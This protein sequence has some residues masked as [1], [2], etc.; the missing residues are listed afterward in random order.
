MTGKASRRLVLKVLAAPA[1][2]RAVL[3]ARRLAA[4]VGREAEFQL[5]LQT[6]MAMLGRWIDP[7][8]LQGEVNF[9][10]DRIAHLA[11][12]PPG[13]ETRARR[14]SRRATNGGKLRVAVYGSFSGAISFGRAFFA[15][16]PD[17]IELTVFD[18]SWR[19]VWADSLSGL[20]HRYVRIEGF[21]E[22][23]A[24]AAKI[25]NE[26]EVDVFCNIKSKTDSRLLAALET[27]CI[28][29]WNA[30]SAPHYGRLFDFELYPQCQRNYAL[31]DRR[32]VHVKTGVQMP[33]TVAYPSFWPTDPRE[34]TARD[35]VP[36]GRRGP[37]IFFHGALYK[38]ADRDYLDLLFRVMADMPATRFRFMGKHGP[39]DELALIFDRARVWGVAER[40]EHLG[41]YDNIRDASDSIVDQRWQSCRRELGRARLWL[42]TFPGIGA[43]AR[44][45]AY[46]SG[47]PVVQ[48]GFPPE[49]WRGDVPIYC[50]WD[51]PHLRVELGVAT[52][53]AAYESLMRR[54]LSDDAFAQAVAEAQ[55]ARLP[56]ILD[57]R[58]VWRDLRAAY[59]DWLARAREAA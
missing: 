3:G 39:T 54:I 55:F 22:G 16:V 7:S 28:V 2:L 6:A 45:E 35:V 41:G 53:P 33:D 18:V 51:L 26:L 42:G 43:S 37:D 40:V 44:V 9:H 52:T 24:E 25:A 56:E 20:N 30:G 29:N 5:W 10:A 48:M 36:A 12:L 50:A 19:G 14:Q 46:Q 15:A 8:S 27:A 32:L 57:Q 31:V 11:R 17:D 13:A 34:G 21:P 58:R 1:T 23:W 59:A 4:R 47:A 38:L 49:W